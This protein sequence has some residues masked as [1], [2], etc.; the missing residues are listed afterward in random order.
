[1]SAALI[2]AL[3]QQFGAAPRAL[4]PLAGGDINSAYRVD[5]ADGRRIFVKMNAS[6]PPGMFRTEA[7]GLDWLAQPGAIRVPARLVCADAPSGLRFLALEWIEPGRPGP[8]FEERFGR[9]LARLHAAGAAEF[10][11]EHDNFIG[12]LAQSNQPCATWA[13]FYGERRLRPQLAIAAGVLPATLV[14]QL[15]RV[16]DRL[17]EFVGPPEP[18][19]RLHGDLWSGNVLCDADGDACLIDPAVYGGHR[20]VDLAMLQL[21][22]QPSPRFFAAY[23][24]ELPLAKGWRWRVPL[25]QLYPLLVHV[26]LFGG[27]YVS[28]L[29]SKLSDFR[30]HAV[31]VGT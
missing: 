15:E 21:F 26:N 10:G 13:E 7:R 27:T 2:A 19:A 22:G 6:A 24:E 18:P 20:E 1:M 9:A 31:R 29:A 16:V 5:L 25:Y 11:F 28:Q 12:S 8:D 3:E 17:P 4:R 23:E 14:A 30:C